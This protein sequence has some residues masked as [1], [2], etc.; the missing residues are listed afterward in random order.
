[1]VTDAST[2]NVTLLSTGVI[3]NTG[4]AAGACAPA[5]VVKRPNTARHKTPTCQPTARFAEC[6][7]RLTFDNSPD[8]RSV[9]GHAVLT[10]VG[11]VP[12]MA[13][14]LHAHSILSDSP[15]HNCMVS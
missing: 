13:Q 4:T 8:A 11:N 9:G 3:W 12:A 15:V 6:M 14:R 10:G 2:W 7:S 1:M 5:R